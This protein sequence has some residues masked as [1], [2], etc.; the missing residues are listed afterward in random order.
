MQTVILD[1][2]GK[3]VV[4]D[5]A[6]PA[7]PLPGQARVR[8]RRIGVCGT[9]LHAYQGKQ[10]FF[11]YPRILGHEL[12]VEVIQT[13][14]GVSG[15]QKGDTCCVVPYLNCGACLPCRIGKPNCCTRL[16]VLGV[17]V[18]GGMREEI[19]I[20]AEKL[21][22]SRRLSFEQLALVETLSIGAHAVDRSGV[23]SGETVLVV[24]AGPIGLSV[25]QFAHLAGARI[26]LME[27][28]PRRIDFCA[29]R[30]PLEDVIR[31]PENAVNR[32]RGLLNGD[33]PMVV[34]DATGN[35]ASM[36]RAFQLVS[37]GGRL[38]FVG[39]TQQEISFQGPE[40]HR[41]ELTVLSSRNARREDLERVMG[42]METGDIDSRPWI[43][44]L[45]YPSEIDAVFPSWLDPNTG[46]VKAMVRMD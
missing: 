17:H 26:V 36:I 7:T 25:I 19:L 35:A 3:F 28:S 27:I 9:D 14:D 31:D 38:I 34:F 8:V 18:D 46:V 21:I 41:K 33:L 22:V 11:T 42:D 29:A 30:F 32:L 37:N 1:Q 6:P 20:P 4:Q 23:Q 13:G 10:P 24:G 44:D 39:I 16:E 45:A 15:V 40:F 43:T 12:G 5:T 2:P